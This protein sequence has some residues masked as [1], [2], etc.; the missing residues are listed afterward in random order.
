M[1]AYLTEIAR[2]YGVSYAPLGSIPPMEESDGEGEGDGDG[3]EDGSGSGSGDGSGGEGKKEGLK[4]QEG[5]KRTPSPAVDKEKEEK[6]AAP[7][8]TVV[9]KKPTEED[10]LAARFERLKNLR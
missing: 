4:P 1:D 6:K 7:R 3:K 10:E 9:V 5:G 2:G 8:Q